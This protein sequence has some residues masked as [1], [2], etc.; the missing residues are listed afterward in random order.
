M[1]GARVPAVPGR[2]AYHACVTRTEQLRDRLLGAPIGQPVLG[3]AGPLLFAVLGGLLR[4]WRLDRPHQLVFDET[5]YVKQGVSMLEYGV[6][7]RWRG[8]GK[9]VDPLFTHGNLDVFITD[10]GDMV[11]HPP[12]GKWV[13]A[14]GEWIF[15]GTSSW[16]WRFLGLRARDALDPDDRAHRAPVVP[17]LAAGDDRG[18]PHGIRGSPLRPIAHRSA[19]PHPDVRRP[20]RLRGAAHRP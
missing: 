20:E 17:V 11:V 4:F 16:G 2:S 1:P 13:I 9:I 8:E 10:N 15:G 6:E 12:V 14:F 19:R 7:M 3:W 18:L 5:Y